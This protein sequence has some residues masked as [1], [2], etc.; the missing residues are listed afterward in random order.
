VNL[1]FRFLGGIVRADARRNRERIFAAAVELLAERGASV[2]M[3]DIARAGGLGVGTL[4]RH[5]ADR[6]HLV[7]AIAIDALR[8]LLTFVQDT[9]AQDIPRWDAL[10]R[11]I[12]HCVGLPLA[13][14]KS[15]AEGT[16]LNR[17]RVELATEL[18]DLYERL[19]E[20]A[21][22]EG[23]LRADIPPCEVVALLNVM[24]CRPGARADDHLSRVML[25][26]LRAVP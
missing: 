10:L 24:V 15:L 4:Y 22:R 12:E 23:T 17:E 11:I 25:D 1:I 6:Q 20:Q 7:E 21:Q 16:V 26:G 3:E 8:D 13:L 9:M 18:D 14:L 19:A 2:S 5:F